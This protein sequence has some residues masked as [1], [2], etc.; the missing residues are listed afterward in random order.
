MVRRERRDDG[1]PIEGTGRRSDQAQYDRTVEWE[2]PDTLDFHYVKWDE[3]VRYARNPGFG[4][5]AYRNPEANF[6]LLS[7]EIVKPGIRVPSMTNIE[8]MYRAALT[9]RTILRLSPSERVSGVIKHDLPTGIARSGEL[10]EAFNYAWRCDPMAAFGSVV[11]LSDVVDE[12]TANLIIKRFIEWV[13]APG[14]SDKAM[15]ILEQ[16]EKLRLFQINERDTVTD[17]G[18]CYIKP[19]S[20]DHDFNEYIRIG[21]ELLVGERYIT[22]IKSPENLECMSERQPTD[23]EVEAALFNWWC[24]GPTKSNAVIVGEKNRTRGIGGGQ[25]ARIYS[26]NHALDVATR[27]KKNR[28]E[29]KVIVSDAFFPKIDNI[30]AMHEKGVAGVV[31]PTGSDSDEAVLGAIN[32]YGM[33]ALVPRPEPGNSNRTERAFT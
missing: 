6:S 20:P 3:D 23:E 33:F 13:V 14:Y 15:E 26:L 25:P 2:A 32:K 8:D 21:E 11:G 10:A 19:I 27:K 5:A 18:R 4:A 7:G 31:Y 16:K 30:E 22:Q 1:G 12:D 24:L 17:G 28:A 9:V 29:G